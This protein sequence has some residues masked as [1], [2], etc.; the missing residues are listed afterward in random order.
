MIN[1]ASTDF[2]ARPVEAVFLGWRNELSPRH[3]YI[4]VPVL[5]AVAFAE[6]VRGQCELFHG[7]M[8]S[9]S[10]VTG[11]GGTING[12]AGFVSGVNGNAIEFSGGG[13]AVFGGSQFQSD[14]GSI[15]FWLRKNSPDAQGGIFQI[16]SV[17]QPNSIGVFYINGDE[18]GF[19]VRGNSGVAAQIIKPGVF[20]SGAW[21][22]VVVAWKTVSNGVSM[23][24]FV[25]GL[26]TDFVFLQDDLN[27]S[28][29]QLQM[30]FT[31]FY[32]LGECILDEVRFFDR[33]LLDGE[34]YAEYAYSENRFA[35]Q[36]TV[37]PAS[38]GP[39]QIVN[40]ELLVEGHPF[41]VKGAA[42]SPTPVGFDVGQFPILSDPGVINRDAPILRALGANTIRTFTPP[43]N[44]TLLDTM[45]NNG[46]D[47]IYVIM[48][49][50]VPV[51]GID[52]SD[53]AVIAFH[54]TQFV[55]MVSQFKN[56]P[57][58]LAWGIGNE[59]NLGKSPQQLA[60]WYALAELLAAAA[61]NEEGNS[62]HP[63]MIV[64]GSLIGLGDTAVAADDVSLSSVDMW[65]LNLYFG[66]HPHCH[67]DYY[68]RV[69]SKPLVIT[70][71]G[72][73]ALDDQVSLEYPTT[74]AD[75]VVR[76]WRWVE[77][78]TLG[79]TVFEYSDE[80]WKGST[81]SVHDFGGFSTPTQPDGFSNEEW[82]GLLSATNNGSNPD[83]LTARPA[84][85]DL[86]TEFAFDPGDYDQDADVDLQDY[87]N[88]QVCNG[89]QAIGACGS[90]FDFEIDGTISE[91]DLDGFLTNLTGPV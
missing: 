31:G 63:T 12:S 62:Y 17:G 27:I 39:V 65:G 88:F 6:P 86:A 2:F 77:Q 67:F 42:Y 68:R 49:Y 61:H 81:P 3:A 69:S 8:E 60:D 91:S 11:I 83:I 45:Y 51:S 75:F 72:I 34:V 44:N 64:N 33:A 32:G 35:K 54:Q 66:D 21:N 78:N 40:G 41:A 52:Y 15:S 26:F 10:G 38:T 89:G 16:G 50:F 5:L 36:P 23:T 13:F 20:Q 4:F 76:Q 46:V 70:E 57:G 53:P 9:H 59:V 80:W 71:F 74:H 14:T 55:A 7:A 56:H 47:P 79:A 28:A 37:S 48:G 84:Y 1:A 43:P 24:V 18:I 19:E 25:N 30:G 85:D 87:Q 22:H 58:V 73:D 90:A 29:L 82:W